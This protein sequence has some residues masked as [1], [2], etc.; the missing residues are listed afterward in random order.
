MLCN[1]AAA[2]L[3][4]ITTTTP[5]SQSLPLSPSSSS[6]S[7]SSSS[8]SYVSSLDDYSQLNSLNDL[9]NIDSEGDGKFM[10][11]VAEDGKLDDDSSYRLDDASDVSDALA[12]RRSKSLSP[13]RS[14]PSSS[15]SPKRSSRGFGSAGASTSKGLGGSPK[16]S[17]P[18]ASPPKKSKSLV[19]DVVLQISIVELILFV[20]FENRLWVIL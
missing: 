2:I 11:D 6:S 5:F 20:V 15:T 17:P 9:D 18:R 14:K 7:S 16:N 4:A 19:H 10:Y 1:S 13:P 3:I 8:I 12:V